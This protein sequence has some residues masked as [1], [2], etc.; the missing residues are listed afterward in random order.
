MP[1]L[2]EYEPFGRRGY[3]V[4]VVPVIDAVVF[5]AD[6][7]TGLPTVARPVLRSGSVYLEL[8]WLKCGNAD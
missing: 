1:I 6:L 8:E 7:R 5:E 4:Y 2:C 3:V